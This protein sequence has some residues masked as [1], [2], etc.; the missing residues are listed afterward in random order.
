MNETT[1]T[2]QQERALEQIVSLSRMYDLSAAQIDQA[3]KDTPSTDAPL[4]AKQEKQ[5]FLTAMLGNLGGTMIVSGFFIYA[6]I[7]WED[8]PSMGRVVLS[9]GTGMLCFYIAA[10]LQ[11]H[12]EMHRAAPFLWSL[13]G[14]LIPTGLFVFLKEY[15]PG[16]D[17]IMGGVI[18]FGI[19]AP[20]F[21]LMWRR[22][23]TKT[24]FSF[25][26]FFIMAFVGTLY[27]K[28]DINDP[29]MWL[30]T[31]VSLLLIGHHIYKSGDIW[32]AGRV[33]NIGGIATAGS[34]YYYFGNTDYELIC[35]AAMLG[36]VFLSYI[37]KAREF[38]IISVLMFIAL[39]TKQ[40]GFCAGYR[41]SDILRMTAGVTGL[42]MMFTAH[43]IATHSLSRFFPGCWYFFGSALFFSAAMGIL[44][45]TPYDILFVAFPAFI[46]YISLQLRSRALLISSILAIL[47][48][49][50]YYSIK[51]FADTI[52]WPITL[53]VMG[54]LLIGCCVMA[55]KLN[56]RMQLEA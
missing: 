29:E 26:L 35:T 9:L 12:K 48:F 32:G 8:L 37:V 50:S 40:Y 10:L 3:L 24:L 21:L 39:F 18:V 41:D 55:M 11:K 42:S 14:A 2:K 52:G 33:L 31:G 1:L 53:M 54:F 16:D 56:K 20:M 49:I 15:A 46:L 51:Y 30:P 47:S 5:G 7:I 19:C 38:M 6:A 23:P 13:A 27:E 36:L 25:A 17:P 4:P 45:D 43:W 34:I 22:T 44:Y 28:L